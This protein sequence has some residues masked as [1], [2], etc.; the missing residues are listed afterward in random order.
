MTAKL[1][2]SVYEK[3]WSLY[4]TN[5]F[6]EFSSSSGVTRKSS[7]KE[8]S[9]KNSPA[10]MASEWPRRDRTS[11]SVSSKTKFVVTR[12]DSQVLNSALTLGCSGSSLD[13]NPNH[14]EVSTNA[15]FIASFASRRG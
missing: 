10:F 15:F 2:Q 9:R 1:V 5:R 7:T 6:Q 12:R 14:A 3:S 4:L 11:V 13:T 8:G